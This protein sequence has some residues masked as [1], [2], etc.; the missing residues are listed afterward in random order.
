[1]WSELKKQAK[2]GR[3]WLGR[4][5]GKFQ[6]ARGG[7]N[8]LQSQFDTLFAV[9]QAL[10]REAIEQ[11]NTIDLQERYLAFGAIEFGPLFWRQYALCT[12]L[13]GPPNRCNTPPRDIPDE[14]M[15]GYTMGGRVPVEYAYADLTY[16]DNWPLIYT[17]HEI[18]VYLEKIAKRQTHIY[19]MT[20][21]WMW[22][23][24][25]KYPIKDQHVVNMGSLTPWYE[26]NCLYH[27]AR[28]TTIDYNRIITRTDR[29]KTMTTADWDREQPTF[30]IGW[31]ISSFEHDGLG[32]YGD[33]LDPEGDIK[34][35]KKMK[36]IVKPGGLLFLSV[37]VG[38]DKVIFNNA[39]I[40]GSLRL[41]VLMEGWEQIDTFGLEPVHLEGP[42]HI[43]PIFILRNVASRG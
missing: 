15:P 7:D 33:P 24:I 19:G 39:R 14:M 10:R 36:R 17:D 6:G 34:A 37:P 1:M 32:M 9:N 23:A 11:R 42:G 30:D 29:L 13:Y 3:D 31:S 38:K 8:A 25:E 28:S 12:E 41:P 40:Y 43:Q 22:Q 26:S 27:G 18:D 5:A 16:P 21:V 35:M 20:D 2:R 4:Y